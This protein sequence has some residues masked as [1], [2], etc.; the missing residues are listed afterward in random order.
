[1]TRLIVVSPN[2]DRVIVSKSS[3]TPGMDRNDMMTVQMS[4][5][6]MSEVSCAMLNKIVMIVRTRSFCNFLFRNV[7]S[8]ISLI[9]S[10]SRS[11]VVQSL[12]DS[13]KN[14]VG[15]VLLLLRMSK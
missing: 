13:E 1:M 12:I 2:I 7:I 11:F 14:N 9:I 5:G 15:C 3:D 10:W 8:L 4:R 6:M